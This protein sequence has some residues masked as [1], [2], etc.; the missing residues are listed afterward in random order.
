MSY[1]EELFSLENKVAIVT[2]AARGNGKAISEALLRAG[3]HVAM[4]DI[5]EKEL[6]QTLAEFTQVENSRATA[7][8]RD[9]QDTESLKELVRMIH[10]HYGK[11][12]ILVNNAGI[13]LGADILEYPPENWDKT[14]EVNL[15]GPYE[16]MKLVAGVMKES[17]TGSII[18]VTSL[19]AEVAFPGNPA[20]V[21]FKGALK[22][23]TKAFALDLGEYGIRA[24]NVGPGYM[25]TA[26]TQKSWDDPEMNQSRKDKTMLGRWGAPEDL[27]GVVVLLASDA[28]SY[29][30]GQ[31]FYVDGGWLAKGL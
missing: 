2:G 11:I 29:I 12:D 22:Q 21:A 1:L 9:I 25:R 18:N 3:A 5:L 16:L 27:A 15:K 20:Y 30:T 28:S 23:L 10:R 4:V 13:T 26:M 6:R 8:V 24:N 14:Y 7:Y 19:N 17:S 31:D